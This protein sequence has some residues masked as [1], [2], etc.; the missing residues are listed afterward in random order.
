M[1][2]KMDKFHNCI[3]YCAELWGMLPGL[4]RI[5][6]PVKGSCN[7]KHV[8]FRKQNIADLY[9]FSDNGQGYTFFGQEDTFFDRKNMHPWQW[10][11][12][13]I[14]LHTTCSFCQQQSLLLWK[15]PAWQTENSFVNICSDV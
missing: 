6:P 5:P 2:K 12:C 8:K 13:T 11:I 10:Q 4:A 1:D 7:N 9:R 14:T 15:E 3:F